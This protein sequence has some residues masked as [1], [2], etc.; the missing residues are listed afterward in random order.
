MLR[1]TYMHATSSSRDTTRFPP[2]PAPRWRRLALSL[3]VAVLSGL[4]MGIWQASGDQLPFR[5]HPLLLA[6]GGAGYTG[7]LAGLTTDILLR[8]R[9]RGL[10][11]VA[12]LGMLLAWMVVSAWSANLVGAP[13][14]HAVVGA[15]Y[16][17][18]IGQMAI[19][20]LC[21]LVALLVCRAARRERL[22]S[23]NDTAWV[24][25]GRGLRPRKPSL[26]WRGLV[27]GLILL[28]LLG[29]GLGYTQ[30][31]A[32]LF[33]EPI[34]TLALA[35]AGAGFLGL[36]MGGWCR[37][38]LG[39]R[40]GV[41]RFAI[42]LLTLTAGVGVSQGA[43]TLL[44]GVN[45][46]LG[47]TASEV[48][49]TI[50]GQL[51][52]GG[53]CIVV[54]SLV[55]QEEPPRRAP[56]PSPALTP[57][58]RRATVTPQPRSGVRARRGPRFRLPPLRLPTRSR[59]QNRFKTRVIAAE[60]ERCPYCLDVVSPGDPRGIIVCEVCGTPHHG[61]CWEVAGKCQVPHLNV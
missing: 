16:W 46:L 7:L 21:V 49:W 52:V 50:L 39:G 59:A 14:L 53:L 13:A 41:A 22:S 10:R 33:R 31:Y 58:T 55:W 29:L 36:L 60:E 15:G 43:Y 12:A 56:V 19:G 20:G 3:M 1:V 6:L 2:S 24:A 42:A 44:R 47:Y 35:L 11:F 54:V 38:V 32:Y 23:A 4:G 27:P 30:A 28:P 5:V 48:F 8:A 34:P 51:A 17:L 26:L 37:L 18:E 57:A 9:S 45:P 61:D 40:S 25:D